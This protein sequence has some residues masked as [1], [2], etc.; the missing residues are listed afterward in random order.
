[1]TPEGDQGERVGY[2]V[3]QVLQLKTLLTSSELYLLSE[4]EQS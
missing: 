2:T 1:M 4:K 3:L